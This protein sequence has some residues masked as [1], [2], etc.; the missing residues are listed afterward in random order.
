MHIVGRTPGRQIKIIGT[1]QSDKHAHNALRVTRVTVW[2]EMQ[3]HEYRRRRGSQSKRKYPRENASRSA[4]YGHKTAKSEDHS[5][6]TSHMPVPSLPRWT[7]DIDCQGRNQ[8]PDSP[9][10][11]L[12]DGG[13][14][15]G[16]GGRRDGSGRDGQP[17]RLRCF[18]LTGPLCQLVVND[19]V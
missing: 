7:M 18:G 4:R 9:T 16:G 8:G 6:H 2:R 10:H 13:R 11:S 14:R 15:G 19:D 12:G 3:R 5:S 1:E 17:V